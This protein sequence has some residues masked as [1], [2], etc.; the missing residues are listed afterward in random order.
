ML[1][2]AWSR[3][4]T[5]TPSEHTLHYPHGET[6]RDVLVLGGVHR[7]RSLSAAAQRVLLKSW[8]NSAVAFLL[9]V[10]RGMLTA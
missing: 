5:T 7:V 9:L 6:G 2:W 3:K 8:F 4:A 1:A 10:F